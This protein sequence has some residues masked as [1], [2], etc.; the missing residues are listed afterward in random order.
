MS[1]VN[2][3]RIPYINKQKGYGRKLNFNYNEGGV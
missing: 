1:D 2:L 3:L